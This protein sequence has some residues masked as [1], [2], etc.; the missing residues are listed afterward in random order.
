M[1]SEGEAGTPVHCLSNWCRTSQDDPT[2]GAVRRVV[3]AVRPPAAMVF[4]IKLS[5]TMWKTFIEGR[6]SLLSWEKAGIST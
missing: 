5:S 3:D 2:I 4:L 6:C 1:L